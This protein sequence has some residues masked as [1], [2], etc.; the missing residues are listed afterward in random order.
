MAAP[1][2]PGQGGPRLNPILPIIPGAP[3]P[4]TAQNAP[5][6]PPALGAINHNYGL[7]ATPDTNWYN[8]N[9]EGTIDPI[10]TQL[11][12][13]AQSRKEN[14]RRFMVEVYT[15]LANFLV[16]ARN[17]GNINFT[18][19]QLS[20]LRY[21]LQQLVV[22]V[23]RTDELDM[24]AV[25]ALIDQLATHQNNL[26]LTGGWTPKPRR[27]PTKRRNKKRKSVKSPF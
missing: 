26:S 21:I 13:A 5:P 2:P 24:N 27:K 12:N 15:R 22:D 18:A 6:G 4:A 8:V 3:P 7:G 11:Q 9:I 17:R 23:G 20:D 19:Q 10:L 1:A 16:D 25:N 14:E